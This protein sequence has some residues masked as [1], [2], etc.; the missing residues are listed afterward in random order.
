MTPKEFDKE[1]TRLSKLMARACYA[2]DV[3]QAKQVDIQVKQL[4]QTYQANKEIA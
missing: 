2:G 4:F 3:E 1:L